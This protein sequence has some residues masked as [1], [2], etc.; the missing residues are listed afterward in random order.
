MPHFP[1][2]LFYRRVIAGGNE[3]IGLVFAGPY[4][5]R[6]VVPLEPVLRVT[7]P[8]MCRGFVFEGR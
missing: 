5:N 8:S 2:K 3:P 4:Q 1:K 7:G 6:L